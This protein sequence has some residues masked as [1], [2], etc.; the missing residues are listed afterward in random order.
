M[1]WSGFEAVETLPGKVFGRPVLKGSR[2][3]AD[4]AIENFES[5]E[6]VDD[7]AYNFDLRPEQIR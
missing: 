7:I 3:R 6:S 2:V 1:G 4:A 5:G